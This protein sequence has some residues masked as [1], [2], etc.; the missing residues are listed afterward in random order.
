MEIKNK[1][2]K[3]SLSS[4]VKNSV[5]GMERGQLGGCRGVLQNILLVFAREVYGKP[6]NMGDMAFHSDEQQEGLFF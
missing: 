2:K 6:H 4:V 5:T 3:R 1:L